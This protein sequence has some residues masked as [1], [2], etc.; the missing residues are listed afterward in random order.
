MRDD[1]K[2]EIGSLTSKQRKQSVLS[3]E[4][5]EDD[6]Q[7]IVYEFKDGD[8]FGEV[9][10]VI[11]I[12]RTATIKAI[13]DTTL[14]ELRKSDFQKLIGDDNSIK[15]SL[16][17]VAHERIAQSFRRY[18]IPLFNAVPLDMFH[19]LSRLS[20]IKYYQAGQVICDPESKERSLYVI[21]HGNVGVYVTKQRK[22]QKDDGKENNENNDNDD[23]GLP[24]TWMNDNNKSASDSPKTPYEKDIVSESK[25]INHDGIK[26]HRG[27][28]QQ[29]ISP[30]SPPKN[31]TQFSKSAANT[32]IGVDGERRG[33]NGKRISQHLLTSNL[34]IISSMAQRDKLNRELV[35]LSF[36]ASQA[37]K[38]KDD[39]DIKK[40]DKVQEQFKDVHGWR[41]KEID[42]EVHSPLEEEEE[43]E[44]DDNQSDDSDSRQPQPSPI[45]SPV[46][47]RNIINGGINNVKSIISV[48]INGDVVERSK[49]ETKI[50]PVTPPPNPS[51]DLSEE[52]RTI[53]AGSVSVTDYNGG[54]INHSS[55]ITN[56][57]IN[58]T[59]V[60]SDDGSIKEIIDYDK[61]SMI[62]NSTPSHARY[63]TALGTPN[64]SP[65]GKDYSDI[66]DDDDLES[67]ELNNDQK[68]R[69]RNSNK[70]KNEERRR[71]S[72]NALMK[73]KMKITG[74]QQMEVPLSQFNKTQS[75]GM[76]SSTKT[77]IYEK[78]DKLVR[79][80]DLMLPDETMDK[81]RNQ[82]RRGS[83]ISNLSGWS[84]NDDMTIN[85]LNRN[86]A[87]SNYSVSKNT[88]TLT[89]N[90]MGT[91][92]NYHNGAPFGFD[93]D[94]HS[95]LLKNIKFDP[96]DPSAFENLDYAKA[97]SMRGG[98]TN[99]HKRTFT[100]QTHNSL[101]N[102]NGHH[103]SNPSNN[104]S[105]IGDMIRKQENEHDMKMNN[106][107]NNNQT[108]NS[109]DTVIQY[110]S[111]S[112]IKEDVINNNNN[113]NMKENE[114]TNNTNVTIINNMNMS[115]NS[116]NYHDVY[117]QKETNG[118]KLRD[119]KSPD[120]KITYTEIEV[121]V[122]GTGNF[123]G[124]TSLM[125]E[126]ETDEEE[127]EEL[128]TPKSPDDD[129]DDDVDDENK[130]NDQFPFEQEEEDDDNNNNNNN[131]NNNKLSAKQPSNVLELIQSVSKSQHKV[132]NV[133]SNYS[134]S[135]TQT[136]TMETKLKDRHYGNNNNDNNDNDDIIR[137]STVH[138]TVH[139]DDNNDLLP[140][141]PTKVKISLT[142]NNNNN[143]NIKRK[144]SK[145]KIDVTNKQ[146][147]NNLSYRGSH[148]TFRCITSCVIYSITKENLDE[149]FRIIPSA[150]RWFDIMLSKYNVDLDTV[151]HI[152]RAARYFTLFLESEYAEENIHYVLSVNEYK[153][154][155]N[156]INKENQLEMAKIICNNF[157]SDYGQQ[158]INV[159]Y[160]QR[161]L[162]LDRMNNNDIDLNIFDITQKA[163]Y[164]LLERDCFPRF[165]QSHFFHEFLNEA[166]NLAL[167]TQEQYEKQ[168][169]EEN[170][171]IKKESKLFTKMK[172]MKN[173]FKSQNI[174]IQYDPKENKFTPISEINEKISQS[175][176]VENKQRAKTV[177]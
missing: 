172:N 44:D 128:N 50:Y 164:T 11:K 65:N 37:N 162:I 116:D 84:G 163:I 1:E 107:N 68:I 129:D 26:H 147:T 167:L 137:P 136:M 114:M 177:I 29:L 105:Q 158:Q 170:V 112:D 32:P 151:L 6:N 14:L 140:P 33:H 49:A 146:K 122:L 171:K 40:Y 18:K 38:N 62:K 96:S 138:H 63:H 156:H 55:D 130:N 24:N 92:N 134:Q 132:P 97:L 109:G 115:I 82:S 93:I 117:Q 155:Y 149:F 34:N 139:F 28:S 102:E 85:E 16:Q 90:T 150:R 57:S 87:G 61:K 118:M 8:Y 74:P 101:N 175:Q 30:T 169:K 15:L 83:R 69:K 54:I 46:K 89:I 100:P 144:K 91:N 148:T 78:N 142:I 88:T 106:N 113:N 166:E 71:N 76:Y 53:L 145:K 98:W 75:F 157:I 154:A 125:E 21:A 12:P 9:S 20:E 60:N 121:S 120:G 103:E 173:P 104:M 133:S 111:S 160:N 13:Q 141:S 110:Q 152:P 3:E 45:P 67:M 79:I 2:P 174:N 127:Y 124:E 99:G 168:Q 153:E 35:R 17:Q 27:M 19:V 47:D 41:K 143:I 4:E 7:R 135:F 126:G 56:M 5:D 131:D 165:K 73:M 25:L 159:A 77:N 80:V 36:L 123:F 176:F 42:E 51:M 94:K 22:Q 70:K 86:R 48:A 52:K 39:K 43:E 31:G 108:V 58:I 66:N 119:F 10:L 161:K 59:N 23:D 81:L 72:E 95:T 64:K